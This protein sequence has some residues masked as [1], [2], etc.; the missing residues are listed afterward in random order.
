MDRGTG[1]G[2]IP[3]YLDA[4]ITILL[5]DAD[6]FM[7]AAMLFILGIFTHNFW[8]FT[9]FAGIYLYAMAHFQHH[10]PRGMVGNILHHYGLYPYSGY[11]DGAITVFRG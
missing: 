5:W 4:P 1:T 11:P 7:P 8:L 6:V 2:K 3:R 9:S 10:L